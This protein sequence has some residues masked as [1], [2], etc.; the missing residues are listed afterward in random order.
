MAINFQAIVIIFDQRLMV[1]SVQ[2]SLSLMAIAL[3][4]TLRIIS[5]KLSRI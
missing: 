2:L 3:K 1:S 5:T 4:Q